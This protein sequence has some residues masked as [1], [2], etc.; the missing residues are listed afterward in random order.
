[1]D[2]TENRIPEPFLLMLGMMQHISSC[3]WYSPKG[4]MKTS[5]GMMNE[6]GRGF[7]PMPGHIKSLKKKIG[8]HVVLCCP[9]QNVPGKEIHD[10][11][12]VKLLLR[13]QI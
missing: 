12:Q 8:P 3:F 4:V 5:V 13:V 1:V 2:D 9:S 10:H 11:S 6:A 7:S